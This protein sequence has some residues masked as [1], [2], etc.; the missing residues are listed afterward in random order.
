MSY[1]Y[2]LCGSSF[3]FCKMEVIT[4]ASEDGGRIRWRD[5]CEIVLAPGAYGNL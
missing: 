1:T 5:T 2:Q 3:F 4:L